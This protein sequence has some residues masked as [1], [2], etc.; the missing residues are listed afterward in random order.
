MNDDYTSGLLESGA[1][2]IVLPLTDDPEH[3]KRLVRTCDGFLIPGGQDIDPIRYGKRRKPHT[4]RSATARDRMEQALIPLAI[5]AHKPI[6]GICRGMQ[7]LNVTLGG[8]LHQDINAD[9]PASTR[10]HVQRRPWDEPTHMLSLVPGSLLESIIA[11]PRIGVNSLHHQSVA[12]LGRG[13]AASA[14]SDDG[15]VEGIEMPSEDVVVGV[16]WHPERMWRR[17]PHSKRLFAALTQAAAARRS[18]G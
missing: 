2:P 18:K 6:L 15:V 5:Q 14:I 10:P 3:L 8:T 13:L 17:R 4:H 1:V 16:Q 11:A 12:K 9:L 7:T